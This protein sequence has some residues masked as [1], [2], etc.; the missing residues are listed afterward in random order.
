[1]QSGIT[2]NFAGLSKQ[3]CKVVTGAPALRRQRGST[4]RH[5]ELG[6]GVGV[7]ALVEVAEG[8]ARHGG[9]RGGRA[10]T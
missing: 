5:P 2:T 9:R 8:V 6:E 1:M 3:F 4:Q 10:A 7:L